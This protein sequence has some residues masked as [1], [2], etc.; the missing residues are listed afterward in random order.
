MVSESYKRLKQMANDKIDKQ[1]NEQIQ[2][3]N[4]LF[5]ILMLIL[6]LL[7]LINLF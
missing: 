2:Y 1:G 7:F 3:T 4:P 6:L 5:I